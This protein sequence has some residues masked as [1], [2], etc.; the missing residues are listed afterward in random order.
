M[1]LDNAI[2]SFIG[3]AVG[4]ALGTP[5]EFKSPGEFEPITT[6]RG[7]GVFRLNPGEWTDD[8]SMALCI[9][10]SLIDKTV[11][12]P[13]DIMERFVRW[14][15]SGYNSHNGR[16]F[17][18][19]TTIRQSL[20]R[21]ET[22]QVMYHQLSDPF[23][24]GNGAIMRFAPLAI[25]EKDLDNLRSI[26]ID[27]TKLT[28]YNDTCIE[29]SDKF[30]TL[31]HKTLNGTSKDDIIQEYAPTLT[32]VPASEI[33]ASGYVVHTFDAACWAIA[34]T[35]TFKDAL[36]MAVNLGEDADTV[37][38]VCGQI[39]GALY[40]MSSIPTEWLDV[41]SWKEKLITIGTQLYEHR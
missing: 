28:H 9:A 12:S 2:G 34:N 26:A 10:D 25:W 40:G 29:Y 27:Q 11:Y 33:R 15:R 39:A 3:L 5:A 41:L 6:M 23:S 22:N 36:L 32:G 31:I 18:I 35:S 38:A 7:G 24:A 19:G 13:T 8:T 4:D 21:F 16:C 30:A 1:K 20:L 14:F 37:G 17:D